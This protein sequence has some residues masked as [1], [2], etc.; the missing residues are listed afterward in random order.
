MTVILQGKQL[1]GDADWWRSALIYQVYPRSYQD[2]N[3]DGI[4]DLKGVH[5]KLDYLA[6]LGVD[7]VWLSPFFQSPMKDFGYDVSDYRAVDPMFGTLEDFDALLARAH[8]LGIRILIDQVL[9]HTSDQ[10]VWFRE[11]RRSRD[12]PR[13]DWF[14]WA[15]PQPDGTPPANWLSIFGGPAWEWD[16]QRRQYYMHNFLASQPDLNFHN[17]RVQDALLDEVRFWLDRGVDGL[18][19][20][21]ANMYVHDAQLRN[22]PPLAPGEVVNGVGRE[23][24]YAMQ[25]PMYNIN[26][27]ENLVFMERL[28]ALLDAYPAT[29]SVGELGAVTNMYKTVAAYTEK[30]RRLH[31]GYSFDFMTPE[32]SASHVRSVLERMQAGIGSGWPCWAFTNH[33]VARVVTRWGQTSTQAPLIAALMLSIRG[34]PCMYQ[35]DEL[36]LPE[37]DVPFELLQDPYGIRFWPDFKGRDG[38]RTPMPW[39]HDAVNAGFSGVQP[40][41]PVSPEHAARAVD[42]Q[43]ADPASVLSR[44][45]RFIHWRRTQPCLLRGEQRML[46]APDGMVAFVREQGGR[47]LV[48]AFNLE[49]AAQSFDSRLP[50]LEN[51]SGHGFQGDC[52]ASV[53]DLPPHEVFFGMMDT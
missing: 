21:T 42:V 11:S 19:L 49:A 45:R 32:F 13:A 24:P 38:C 23:N 52:R 47:S 29:T 41:L 3:A 4:G 30:G 9:S 48:C 28:R 31:M 37:A 7:A 22:N 25:N 46:D 33:D 44:I 36:G 14:V 26:R 53:I 17:P 50:G 6:W 34:T 12:N 15:D 1:G 39:Q 18:R 40:W 51:L 10:H 8:Q 43:R 27:P 35:G 5:E 20:D 2:S 16:T